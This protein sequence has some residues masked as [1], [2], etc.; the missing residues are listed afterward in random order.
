MM[1]PHE[2]RVVAELKELTEK[3][4]KLRQFITSSSIFREL[5]ADE[6]ARLKTQEF[7]MSVYWRLLGDRI[8]NFPKE[9]A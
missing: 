4:V 1:Q 9:Q 8:E 6:Q 7:L 2:D 3:L 5:P